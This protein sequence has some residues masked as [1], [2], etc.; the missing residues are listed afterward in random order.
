MN[1]QDALLKSN[2]IS[3]FVL[4]NEKC[5]PRFNNSIGQYE[6]ISSTDE[7]LYPNTQVLIDTAFNLVT[8]NNVSLLITNREVQAYN[9]IILPLG[10]Y[11]SPCTNKSNTIKIMLRNVGTT[12][13]K[14]KAGVTKIA[15]FTL[16][17]T[18]NLPFI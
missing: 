3:L 12:T 15:Q 14:I 1:R 7:Q 6:L 8:L 2:D 5:R 18:Y 17:K 13:Y 16:I 9:G 4:T 11:I 10:T